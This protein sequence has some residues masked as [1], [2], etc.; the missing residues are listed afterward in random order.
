MLV[1]NIRIE[2]HVCLDWG[3]QEK[4]VFFQVLLMKLSYIVNRCCSIHPEDVGRHKLVPLPLTWHSPG[5]GPQ[6][7]GGASVEGHRGSVAP[8]TSIP[9]PWGSVTCC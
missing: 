4:W 8:P 5:T 3:Y 2:T 7:M 6:D 9:K 1:V